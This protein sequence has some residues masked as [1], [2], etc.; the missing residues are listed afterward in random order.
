M[1]LAMLSGMWTYS[2]DKGAPLTCRA[3]HHWSCTPLPDCNGVE[4]C[5][6]GCTRTSG[7]SL[8]CNRHSAVVL[9]SLISKWQAAFSAGVQVNA[10]AGRQLRVAHAAPPQPAACSV[11]PGSLTSGGC[12]MRDAKPAAAPT[13]PS[14]ALH[15][16]HHAT[17]PQPDLPRTALAPGKH[18]ARRAAR[19]GRLHQRAQGL[20]MRP[21]RHQVNKLRAPAAH[22]GSRLAGAA[23][24][25]AAAAAEAHDAGALPRHCGCMPCTTPGA[26]Y[27][28]AL[29][30]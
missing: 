4:V 7:S 30:M 10:E 9:P 23:A 24:C 26:S 28:A 27:S 17:Q 11:A 13:T 21:H 29:Q 12:S 19:H 3:C 15:G 1:A 18:A 22:A 8:I 16:R 5:N 6:L 25:R 14:D 2:N 20:R